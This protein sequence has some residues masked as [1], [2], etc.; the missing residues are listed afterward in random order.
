MDGFNDDSVLTGMV[1]A[2]CE[3]CSDPCTASDEGD[4]QLCISCEREFAG[5]EDDED[6]DDEYID[7][8]EF[9]DDEN[10]MAVQETLKFVVQPI[11]SI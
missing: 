4:V 6:E 2:I 3:S 11:D 8:I 7:D 1:M 9:G 10:D 5:P